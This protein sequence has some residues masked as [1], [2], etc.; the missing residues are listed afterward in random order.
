VVRPP[1]LPARL[2]T[3]V[4]RAAELAEVERLVRDRRLVTL[5]GVGGCGKTRLAVETCHRIADTGQGGGDG[6]GW[7]G[8]WLVDL[9]LVADPAAVAGTVAAALGLPVEPTASPL[10]RLTAQLADRDLLL[11]LDTCGHVLDAAANLADALLR[12]CPGLTILATSREPLGV[13][14]ETVWRV[15]ALRP[16]DA[17][18]LFADRAALVQ[19]RFRLTEHQPDVAAVCARVDNIPLAVELAAAWVRV[20]GPAQIAAGLEESGRLLSGGRRRTAPRHRTMQASMAWSHDLLAERER[21]LFRRLAVF[22][23]AFT[24]DAAGYVDGEPVTV[25]MRGSGPRSRPAGSPAP[26]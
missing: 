17:V 5:T 10:P 2:T 21:A 12:G 6:A 7:D 4:G 19:P 26:G 8:A 23:G 15:P 14:G 11:C 24:A 25:A 18:T 13:E 1:E 3:F 20:L 16:D 9:G 22:A